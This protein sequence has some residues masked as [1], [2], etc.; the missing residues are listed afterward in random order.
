MLNSR[1]ISFWLLVGVAIVLLQSGCASAPP[2]GVPILVQSSTSSAVTQPTGNPTPKKFKVGPHGTLAFELPS[3]WRYK[4]Y[5]THPLIPA[6]FRL[7]APDKSAAMLVS[8]S[9]DGIGT[10]KEAPDMT[11]LERILRNQAEK[12]IRNAVEKSVEVK[13][14]LLDD[15]YAQYAQFT[16]SMWVNAEVAEGNYRYSTDGVFRCGHL[17]GSFTVYS[18]DMTGESFRPALAVV[19]SLRKLDR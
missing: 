7:D 2:H 17:W 10:D 4:T 13:T 3:N 5:R 11:Q 15:G 1:K 14:V 19:Q 6:A 9:W 8:V 16:E 12:R 18:Q